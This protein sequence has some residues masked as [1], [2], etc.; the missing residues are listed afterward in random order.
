MALWLPL[1]AYAQA[2][3][4][5]VNIT[6]VEATALD[7][8]E[9]RVSAFVSVTNPEGQ[10]Y[11]RLTADDFSVFENNTPV[12]KSALNVALSTAPMTITLLIDTSSSM[13]QPG[14]DGVR[15]IDAAKDAAIAFVGALGEKDQVAVYAYDDQA[16][17]Q[18]DFTYDLGN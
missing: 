3:D 13:A 11:T 17:R 14:P 2:P 18:Q 1:T 9:V 7:T 5:D 12:E 10:P 16:R 4:G 6:H 8:G 15:A